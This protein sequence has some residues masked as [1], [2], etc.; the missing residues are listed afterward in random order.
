MATASGPRAGR[1]GPLTRAEIV[2]AAIDLVAEQGMAA[3]SVRV[4]AT[5]LGASPMSLYNHIADR[6]D[7]EVAM[8]D[9]VVGSLDATVH[10]DDPSVRLV[11]RFTRLH[12]HFADK[13]WAILLLERGDLVSTRA[14]PFTEACV[15]DIAALGKDPDTAILDLGFLWHVTV[16]ELIDRHPVF[17]SQ[18]PS[19][20]QRELASLTPDEAPHY[21]AVQNRLDPVGATPPCH[22]ERSIRI[23]VRAIG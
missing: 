15:A 12:D 22:F 21:S 23:A 5:R 16:G 19:Q 4:L 7:L 9:D 17:L 10:D 13:I 3:L 6:Q 20:R 8:L 11:E 14:F 1:T 18:E 2:R